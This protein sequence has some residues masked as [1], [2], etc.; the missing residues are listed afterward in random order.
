MDPEERY[1]TCPMSNSVIAGLRAMGS[2]T[3]TRAGLARAGVQVI[4][5]SV[6]AIDSARRQARLRGGAA[7]A[8]DRLVLAAGIRF[9]WGRPQ[10]YSASAAV[11]MPH[12]WQAGAQTR[13][14]A[15]QLAAMR[16][17]GVVAISVPAGPMRCPP[18]PFERASLMAAYLSAPRTPRESADLRRQQSFPAPGRLQRRVAGALSRHHRMDPG[19]RGRSARARRR[20]A[21]D[22]STARAARS[23]RT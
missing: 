13:L 21:H 14:L 11:R 20:R 19:D 7:L 22:C 12:A 17:G 18:G 2:I 10:G 3:V 6:V 15:A 1:V 9:L 8:Y 4:R 16:P 23:A 5:D